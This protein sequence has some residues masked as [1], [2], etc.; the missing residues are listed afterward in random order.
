LDFAGKS[1]GLWKNESYTRGL[2]CSVCDEGLGLRSELDINF[3]IAVGQLVL[4]IVPVS[5][6][7]DEF[8]L[9][10]TLSYFLQQPLKKHKFQKPTGHVEVQNCMNLA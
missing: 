3:R 2:T 6:T 10:T 9:S 4:L 1:S 5:F 8:Q 7:S